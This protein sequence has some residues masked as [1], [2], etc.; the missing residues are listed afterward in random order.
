MEVKRLRDHLL[1]QEEQHTAALVEMERVV[2]VERGR[3]HVDGSVDGQ[4]AEELADKTRRLDAALHSL[5]NLQSA[6]EAF[7]GGIQLDAHV[8]TVL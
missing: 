5:D 6:M 7:E 4:L 8:Y 3:S 2:E 1:D